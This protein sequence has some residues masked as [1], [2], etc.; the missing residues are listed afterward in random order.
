MFVVF[1][2]LVFSKRTILESFPGV[3][4]GATIGS[5]AMN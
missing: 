4:D 2:E 5:E 3:N 1:L